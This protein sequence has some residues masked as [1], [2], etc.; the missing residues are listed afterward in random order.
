M[1]LLSMENETKSLLLAMAK[2]LREVA[3]AAFQAQDQSQK[4]HRALLDG[5]S[6]EYQASYPQ[7]SQV[8]LGDEALKQLD[9]LIQSLE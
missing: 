7:P 6:E 9:S 3:E 1:N 4:T 2:V 8:R 5:F